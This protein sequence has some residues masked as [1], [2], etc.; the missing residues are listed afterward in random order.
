MLWTLWIHSLGISTCLT[1]QQH[2]LT[3][4]RIFCRILLPCRCPISSKMWSFN[5]LVVVITA[6]KFHRNLFSILAKRKKTMARDRS[7]DRQG[8]GLF[9]QQLTKLVHRPREQLDVHRVQR[10]NAIAILPLTNDVGRVRKLYRI[11]QGASSNTSNSVTTTT[12]SYTYSI[13]EFKWKSFYPLY[14][15]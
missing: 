6:N 4:I 7:R 3:S 12:S 8:A 2:R 11:D 9:W 10:A 15:I 5:L 13:L 1:S 14:L